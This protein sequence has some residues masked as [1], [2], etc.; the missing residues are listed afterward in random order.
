MV[1]ELELT[2][3]IENLRL[4]DKTEEELASSL[5]ESYAWKDED[6][7]LISS[8]Y[9]LARNLHQ[10]DQ[11]KDQSYV[12]HLLRVANRINGYLHIDDAEVI[13]AA[14]LH[15]SVED[16]A[17]EISPESSQR[18]P[19]L[20]QQAAL[21]QISGLFSPRT[22]ELVAAVTNDPSQGA[23]LSYEEKLAKYT[24]KV[25]KATST[26]EGWLIKF[27]DWCDN[28][29]GIVH[30]TETLSSSE[31]A[32]FQRKYGG[33]VLAT[34]ERRFREPDVQATLDWAAKGYVEHQL[35]LGHERLLDNE[36]AKVG[37]S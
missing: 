22:A 12:Y 19:G 15:D 17:A 29:L 28:G 33:D 21:E 30:G 10:H 6:R 31:I 23:E 3:P 27:S 25:Q 35:T 5:I 37:T 7:H 2:D 16:H 14:L 18:D 36:M 11:Y 13:A 4:K 32:H 20:R 34:F 9:E 26:P 8:A 1:E 24:A